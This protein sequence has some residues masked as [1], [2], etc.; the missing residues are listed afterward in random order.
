MTVS[1]HETAMVT[2][3]APLVHEGRILKKKNRREKVSIGVQAEYD[4]VAT[5]WLVP[6]NTHDFLFLD[7]I[8]QVTSIHGQV[9]H[10]ELVQS[11]PDTSAVKLAIDGILSGR[12]DPSVICSSPE[13]MAE[14]TDDATI[15]AIAPN[16]VR[17][18]EGRE[19]VPRLRMPHTSKRDIEMLEDLERQG[20]SYDGVWKLVQPLSSEAPTFSKDNLLPLNLPEGA[21][22]KI[23]RVDYMMDKKEPQVQWI[24][25]R[26]RRLLTAKHR[27]VVDV[28]GGRGDLATRIAKEFPQLH[29]TVVDKNESS[30]QAGVDYA[31]RLG[32]VD[33]MSFVAGDF[34]DY[35][36]DVD[37]V[38][39]LHAC[40]DL[41]DL[42]IHFAKTR[43][44]DFVVCPCCYTKRCIANFTPGWC[45]LVGEGSSSTLGRLAETDLRP[46]VSRRAMQ[47]INSL[48]MHC[49]QPKCDVSLEEYSSDL[50]KRNLVL[51]GMAKCG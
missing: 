50:S 26:L 8:V 37:L 43:G 2:M 4:A 18:I 6:R 42:A 39:A 35:S 17:R 5:N 13:E 28:G 36:E 45:Q 27:H 19:K 44:C 23:E 3:T 21:H 10:V 14:L 51:V 7:A 11:A 47:I 31:K 24:I 9:Q 41:S 12:H 16:L 32:V 46:D 20:N 33:R 49:L 15:K 48:R 38:V 29:V 40:G 25:S 22:E 34:A 30:M 1:D